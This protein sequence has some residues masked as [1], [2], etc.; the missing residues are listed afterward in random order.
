MGERGRALRS[1]GGAHS[2]AVKGGCDL[3]I[4]QYDYHPWSS[5]QGNS[6][7]TSGERASSKS[8]S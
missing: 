1:R 2:L 4:W 3:Y 8:L 5:H 6:G 7:A